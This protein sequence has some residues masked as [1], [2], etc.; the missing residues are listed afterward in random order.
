MK[1]KSFI[2]Y[3]VDEC[4]E[5]ELVIDDL[6][7]IPSERRKGKGRELVKEAIF[8]AMDNDFEKITLFANPTDGTISTQ[9]LVSFYEK[10]GFNS[11]GDCDQ[12][13]TYDV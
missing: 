3:S 5:K 8:Y 6:Y 2:N 12:L 4:D 9:D 10:C 13:M 1:T 11:H 7:I